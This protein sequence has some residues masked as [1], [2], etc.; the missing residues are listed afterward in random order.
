MIRVALFLV[1]SLVF[2]PLKSQTLTDA[3]RVSVLTVGSGRSLNDAFGHNAF[4]VQDDSLGIDY[5][6][7]YGRYD[8]EAPNFYLKFARG[9]LD[10]LLGLSYYKD[11]IQA[12]KSQDRTVK[13][14]W[15]N[16]NLSQKQQLFEFLKN[17]YKDE[18]RAYR[19]DFFYNN[20]ATKI[21]DVLKVVTQ[22]QITFNTPDGFS[23]KTF[24][25]LIQ[26]ELDWNTW[27]SLGIDIALGSVIDKAATAEEHM[28]LPKYIYTFFE[29]ASIAQ[30]SPLVIRSE[31]V[32]QQQIAYPKSSFWSSPLFVMLLLSFVIIW[33]TFK[34]RKNNTNSRWLDTLIVLITDLIGFLLLL[35][36]FATDHTATAFN[37]NLLW[38]FPINILLIFQL[39]RQKLSPW[40]KPYIKLLIVLI[41]L[42]ILH[43]FTG[44]QRFAPAL[45][46]LL[47]ALVY[48][49]V[50]WIQNQEY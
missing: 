47:I 18:N 49:Y 17:N 12:Y 13:Q 25:T 43:W 24:R 23:P 32:Y 45:L 39:Y 3:S 2:I 5:V 37:Y 15:L 33:I 14:Q 9:K 29:Q 31:T 4:R 26:D 8:F 6:F 36:W 44:V 35:L 48:R 19:Y 40:V 34:D 28:F 30:G 41:A 10:Y 20:C 7:D 21:K 11:F 27:G 1:L 50:F 22:N 16:L 46:P 38:A 42:L